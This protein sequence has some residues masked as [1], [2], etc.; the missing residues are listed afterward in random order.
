VLR[1]AGA[2]LRV[3]A[4]RAEAVAIRARGE[5]AEGRWGE[6]DWLDDPAAFL[7]VCRDRG[8]SAVA[9]VRAD[10][11][12]VLE[13]QIG[14]W[15]DS[16][17]RRRIARRAL[18]A[19]PAP[20]RDRVVRSA[21]DAFWS[22]VRGSA[23]AS[24]WRRLTRSSYVVLLYHRLAGEEK[25]GQEKLDVAPRLFTAHLRLL[26]RLG[27]RALS[28][29]DLLAFHGGELPQLP[30]RC[31]AL[32]LDDGTMDCAEPLL[33]AVPAAPQLF[34]PT[35]EVGGRAHW[36]EGEPLLG[37]EDV[38]A[39]AEAGVAVGSHARHH[40]RLTEVAPG[41][42]AEELGGSMADLLAHVPSPLRIVAYPH[43]GNDETVRRVAQEAGFEAAYGTRKGRNGV[44]TNRYALRRISVYGYD[45]K[46]ALLW[47]V[48]TGEAIPPF[49]ERWRN[50]RLRLFRWARRTTPSDVPPSE[51]RQ[52]RAGF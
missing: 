19:L 24:E 42:L 8:R 38:I 33:E 6:P 48:A 17:Y 47:K 4:A 32:T 15:F 28:A 25:P 7:A 18:L 21:T 5:G 14:T 40:V 10:P 3:G 41:E 12:L 2:G 49:W 22:G 35:E 46:L 39:L 13:T 30:A 51:L 52:T 45:G 1:R 37:W 20:I 29:E 11:S 9:R 44:G 23:S 16:G 43:G 27:F 31:F 34:V 36:L 26:R 50:R